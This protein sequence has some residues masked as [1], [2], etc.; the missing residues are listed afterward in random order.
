MTATQWELSSS[1]GDLL[2]TTGVTGPAAGMG[3]R[4]TIA[5][6]SWHATV[7]W[8]D[9]EPTAVD[10][11][12]DVDS[13]EVQRG[14]GGVKGLSGAEKSMARSNALKSLDA[15]RFPTIRFRADDISA[16]DGGY[17]LTGTLAIHGRPR[18]RSVDLRTEDLGET[19]RMSCE[20]VVSHADFGVKP[21]SMMMGAMK[22]ADDVTV[23]FTAVHP[24]G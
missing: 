21:Y 8:T 9:G 16:I 23:S 2:V 13:L 24:K 15:K 6:T 18:D 4:L 1:D 22:V 14:E 20:S 12:V 5:M 7:S 11:T 3:H 17:R 19:W 10:L